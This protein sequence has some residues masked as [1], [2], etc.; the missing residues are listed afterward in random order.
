MWLNADL[1]HSSECMALNNDQSIHHDDD[2]GVYVTQSNEIIGSIGRSMNKCMMHAFVKKWQEFACG[3][4][5][6]G[7]YLDLIALRYPGKGRW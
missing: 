3:K 5:Y 7:D 2:L 6:E 1:C 4:E